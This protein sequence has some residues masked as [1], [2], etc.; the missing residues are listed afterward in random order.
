MKAYDRDRFT[1]DQSNSG[2]KTKMGEPLY[3]PGSV[4]CLYGRNTWI[5]FRR[6]TIDIKD[7]CIETENLYS[8]S[9]GR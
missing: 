3:K 1:P 5:R 8:P 2:W 7:Y 4:Y 9:G 6:L